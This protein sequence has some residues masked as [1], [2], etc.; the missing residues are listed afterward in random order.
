M[1]TVHLYST[2]TH[3]HRF[4]TLWDADISFHIINTLV[5]QNCH[6]TRSL[7]DARTTFLKRAEQHALAPESVR[8]W[9]SRNKCEYV[10]V[11]MRMAAR[12]CLVFFRIAALARMGESIKLEAVIVVS[13][14]GKLSS[15]QRYFFL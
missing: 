2:K 3:T 10:V 4:G 1:C 12:M 7:R 8:A 13:V 9:R 5:R 6:V 15:G 14:A 11:H